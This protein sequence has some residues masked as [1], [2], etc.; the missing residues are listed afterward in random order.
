[1]V[2]DETEVEPYR[3]GK[4]LVMWLSL[5]FLHSFLKQD[6]I[7][8][9][10][11]DHGQVCL[12]ACTWSQPLLFK[13]V[14]LQTQ[15]IGLSSKILTLK[16][17]RHEDDVCIVDDPHGTLGSEQSILLCGDSVRAV[18]WTKQWLGKQKWRQRAFLLFVFFLILGDRI[19]RGQHSL[20]FLFLRSS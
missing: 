20:I 12:V 6:D 1:M 18:K 16:L 9:W 2:A 14:S 17:K 10:C 7:L 11:C 13:I 19:S 8:V 4:P 3:K 5:I 15:A